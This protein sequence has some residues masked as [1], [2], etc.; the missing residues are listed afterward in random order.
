MKIKDSFHFGIQRKII[1]NMTTESW[2]N[3]P[4]IVFNYE[5]DVTDFVAYCKKLNDS[6]KSKISLNTYFL[7]V[8]IEGLK[9]APILNSHIEFDKK[10]V[11]GKVTTFENIDISMP[12]ILPND[13]MMTITLHDLENKSVEQIQ[14]EMAD[15]RRRAENTDLN[16][17]M[18]EVSLENTLQSLKKGQIVKV[19]NRLIGSKTGKYKVKTLS[20]KAKREYEKIPKE[21]RITKDD[22][23]QGTVTV[24]NVG[25]L[26][27]GQRGNVTLLEVVPPQV[28]TYCL[29]AVQERAIVVTHE[30]GEKG[31]EVRQV[32]PICMAIDHRALDFGQSVPF[33]KR[34]DE[35]FANPEQIEKW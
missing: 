14:N 18:F 22:I 30:N 1:A 15:I 29:A 5:P 6:R 12:M 34:M 19:I 2:D 32:L 16:E 25:S 27:R 9:A 7:K 8:I 17:A 24:S 23:R 10:L 21:N 35:I 31:I 13:E 4:H 33:M 20:G 26:Y 11:R 3:I 28:S